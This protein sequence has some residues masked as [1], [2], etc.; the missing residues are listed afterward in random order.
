MIV[1]QKD[2][3]LKNRY[4]L[5]KS[6][7]QGG[8]SSVWLAED[9]KLEILVAL[10]FLNESLINDINHIKNFRNEWKIA[11]NLIHPN[12][13]KVYEYHADTTIP[14]YAMQYIDG[15][16]ISI[17]SK[18]ELQNIIRPFLS[19]VGAVEYLHEKEIYHGDIKINNILL[20]KKGRPFLIDFGNSN[21]LLDQKTNQNKPSTDIKKCISRDIYS[22]GILLYE[23]IHGLP[24][25]N[26]KNSALIFDSGISSELKNLITEMVSNTLDGAFQVKDIQ[27]KFVELGYKPGTA[28]IPFIENDESIDIE[29]ISFDDKDLHDNQVNKSK[30]GI[31]LKK[32]L[33]SLIFIG[34]LFLFVIFVLP[35][36]VKS[37]ISPVKIDTLSTSPSIEEESE[38]IESLLQE[39]IRADE[40]LATFL[41]KV[42]YLKNNGIEKWGGNAYKSIN[43][44]YQEGDNFY[45]Q[46]IYKE[47]TDTYQLASLELDKL[48][49]QIDQIL[50]NNINKGLTALNIDNFNDAIKYFDIVVSIEPKNDTYK[51]YYQRALNLEELLNLSAQGRVFEEELEFESAR[52]TYQ[53]ALKLDGSYEP[54][55]SL[56]ENLEE[57]I[58]RRD[59]ENNM[60]E[61]FVALKRNNFASARA[62]FEK[63]SEMNPDTKEPHDAILQ[64]IEKEKDQKI[65]KLEK[66]GRNQEEQELWELAIISYQELLKLD[67][68]LLFA[69]EGL[70]R[71]VERELLHR[72]IQKYI[73]DFDLLTEPGMI[74]KATKRLLVAV[75]YEQKPRLKAQTMEL[76]R[77]LKLANTPVPISLVSDNLTDVTLFRIG[78]LQRFNNKK[79]IILPGKYVALGIRNGYRDVRVEFKV[80]P[81]QFLKPIEVICKEEI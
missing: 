4:K 58:K 55:L 36:L 5:V 16:E 28:V 12:I 2:L 32:F 21:N 34:C 71:S 26:D 13:I 62:L 7:G 17:L 70:E 14:F 15:Y 24:L 51:D 39:R 52:D 68:D 61:G 48:S 9:I 40:A 25:E 31:S 20:D 1:L 66:Q 44:I 80:I 43:N 69:K 41:S 23:I 27:S 11:H 72:N 35:E 78:K 54:I 49:N 37:N 19:I 33:I 18:D 3:I 65:S 42:S 45:L 67:H 10:K 59:F 8:L 57:K 38:D 73:D 74:K 53:L 77:L 29:K 47:A 46:A 81:E 79:I 6:L 60:S 50:E 75:K 30:D 76:K 22:L 63:A 64:L 56:L